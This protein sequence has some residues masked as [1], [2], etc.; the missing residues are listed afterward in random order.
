MFNANLAKLYK[1]TECLTVDEQ[2]FLYRC[3]TRFTQYIP[4]NPSKYGIKVWWICDLKNAYP[5]RTYVYWEIKGW[6]R[7]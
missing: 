5:L 7:N 3:R 1:P 2:L 6:T 4:S